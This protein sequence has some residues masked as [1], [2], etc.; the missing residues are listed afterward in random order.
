M[1]IPAET[2]RLHLRYTAWASRRLAGAAAQLSEEELARDFRSADKSVLGTLV[3][4]YAADRLWLGR[5]QGNPPA[6]FLDPDADMKL[7][8]LEDDWPALDERWRQWAAALTDNSVREPVRYKDLKGNPYVTPLWQILLHV[9]NH[10]THHRGQ[11]SAMMRA[12]GRTPP[13]LDLIL[14]Y[15]EL[16]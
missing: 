16:G 12:M 5:I 14:F 9:V 1:S 2:L 4:V 6:R 15:R 10:G 7:S 13:P 3:H 11:V 8:V